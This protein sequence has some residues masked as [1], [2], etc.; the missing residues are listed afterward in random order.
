MIVTVCEL[1]DE[2]AAFGN[3][4]TQLAEHVRKSRSGLVLLPDMAFSSWFADSGM[5][6]A[7][8]WSQALAEHDAWERRLGELGAALVLGSRPI[9]FGNER[10]DEGFVWAADTGV[11]SVH[12]RATHDFVPLEVD[13]VDIG[14]MIGSEMAARGEHS[15]GRGEVDAHA[16]LR[17]RRVRSRCPRTGLR[18]SRG[19]D[20]SS[21]RMAAC[22]ARPVARSRSFR[23]KSTCR[24]SEH[25]RTRPVQGPLPTGSTR[26]TRELPP[27]TDRFSQ[28]P[29]CSSRSKSHPEHASPRSRRRPTAPGSRS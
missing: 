2:R 11:R 21:R 14:F 15:Y 20:G 23:W 5:V 3:S 19:R 6:D 16:Q 9:D 10:Y 28:W 7:A 22:S 26:W 4:W 24:A 29:R 18:R 25:P 8:R 27:T 12:A 17:P 13:G 1:P